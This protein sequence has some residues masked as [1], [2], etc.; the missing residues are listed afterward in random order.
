M[1]IAL[2]NLTQRVHEMTTV[3]ESFLVYHDALVAQLRANATDPVA[4]AALAD[5]LE[6]TKARMANAMAAN[7][8]ASTEPPVV[9]PEPVVAVEPPVD[10]SQPS[11]P[12][13]EGD[14]TTP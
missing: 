9:A 10:E 3:A 5:E 2:D 12:P 13:A 4:V 11:A 6:A 14:V 7:T 8:A 1:S